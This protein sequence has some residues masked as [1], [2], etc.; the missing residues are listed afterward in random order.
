MQ[1]YGTLAFGLRLRAPILAKCFLGQKDTPTE[2]AAEGRSMG[3]AFV[4]SYGLLNSRAVNEF[5]A[6]VWESEFATSIL[7]IVQIHDA[8]YYLVKN[9]LATL[10]FVNTHLVNAVRWQDTP[11]L[12]HPDVKLGGELSLFWPS[13]ANEIGIPN[14]ATPEE[15]LA[16]C[17][18][19]QNAYMENQ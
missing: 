7:P 19:G 1:G 15:I 14:D 18:K 11:E 2:A 17:Q 12:A 10:H 3:N 16:I 5:M 8:S 4:Q 13:W 9:D 6:K